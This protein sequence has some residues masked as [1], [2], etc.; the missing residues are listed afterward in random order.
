MNYFKKVL[1][2]ELEEIVGSENITDKLIDLDATST[3][4][5]FIDRCYID[6]VER[7]QKPELIVFPESTE[8]VSKILKIANNYKIP[9]TPRGGGAGDT[10]GSLPVFGGILLDMLKMEKII[11]VDKNNMNLTVE[12]GIFQCHLEEFLNRKGY[13]LNFFPASLYCSTLGGFIA[14]RGSGTLSSKYGKI[15]NLILSMEVVMPNG[16][17]LQ[18]LPVPDHSTGPDLNRIFLGSEGTIGVITNVTL[19][20]FYLPQERRFSAFLFDSLPQAIN[21]AKEVMINRFEPNVVRIYDEKDTKIVVNKIL[22]TKKEGSFMVIGFDG[23]KE[24]VDAQ[25]KVAFKCIQENGGINLGREPGE[26]WWNN[27]FKFYYPPYN[28][29]AVPV[30]HGVI[31]SCSSFEN[32]LKIY[33]A[34]K[35]AIEEGFKEWDVTYIAHFSHWYDYGASIYPTFIINKVPDE[36]DEQ[37]KLYHRIWDIGVKVAVENGGTVNEHHG[38]GLKLARFMSDSYYP[39]FSIFRDIKKTLDP[40]NIMNP[41]KM[42]LER[43]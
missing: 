38:I 17:I 5:C 2:Y 42:G 35:A 15:D 20:M 21:A 16:R 36:A 18:T 19:K 24:I 32:I 34:Q 39:G 37:L 29:E 40:K 27:R 23:F 4:V 10:C 8:Q 30:I 12:T 22:G 11:N 31:D 43:I 26:N 25:E 14:N 13:T 7:I 3:D 9:V 6:E 28:L 1:Y 33:Y 41:G